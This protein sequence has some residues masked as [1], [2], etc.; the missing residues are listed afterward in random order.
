MM[1]RYLWIVCSIIFVELLTLPGQILAASITP[2]K[3]A[4]GEGCQA[5]GNNSTAMGWHT[6]ADS[7]SSTA[8]GYYTRAIG[9][10]S[11]TM[12]YNTEASGA[13][14]TAMGWNAKATEHYS[15]AMGAGTWASGRGSTA[16]GEG[17][18]AGG[19]WSF[20]GGSQMQLTDAADHT[21]VW[22]HAEYDN[23]QEIST[24]N[25]FLIFPGGTGGRVGIGTPSPGSKLHV[26]GNGWPES[27]VFL[28]T[29]V[30]G[31]DAG[32]RFYE[33]ASVKG[34]L[35]HD[36]AADALRFFYEGQNQLALHSNGNVGIKTTNP[37]HTLTVNG[38]AAKPGGGEWSVYSDAR[39]KDITGE[40]TRGLDAI[41]GLRPI[42]FHYKEDNPKGLPTDEEYIGFIAQEV[43]EVFPEAVSEGPDGYLDFNMHPVNVA[44]VNAVKELKAENEALRE[45]I[46]EIKAAL[47]M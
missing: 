35:Y 18:I 41:L 13:A 1:N 26:K 46:R 17:T 38:T 33:N 3:A 31:E 19:D 15:T 9:Q 12:G 20:A 40:Y 44:L 6:L 34:H 7:A 27:F 45:E 24:P 47:G 8:M 36:A 4:I 30:A 37:T 10:Y 5:T 43:Q 29:H 23:K 22:G 42:L 28:D 11:T 25:A 14:S 16:M 21:F 32:I 39:L 2:T